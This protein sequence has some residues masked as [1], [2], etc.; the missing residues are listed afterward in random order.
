MNPTRIYVAASS[1]ELERVDRALAGLAALGE[2]VVVTYRWIDDMRANIA[3]G[4]TEADY[5]EEESRKFAHK[6]LRG[7]LDADVTWLLYPNTPTCGAWAE[8]GAVVAAR[9]LAPSN[10]AM[11]CLVISY[12][13]PIVVP[14]IWRHLADVSFPSDADALAWFGQEEAP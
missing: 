4:R 8:L 12:D 11:P 7:V 5:S 14:K 13:G 6:C 2:R 3:A 10:A 9:A 1:R